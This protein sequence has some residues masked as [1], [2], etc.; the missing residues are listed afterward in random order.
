MDTTPRYTAAKAYVGAAI[1]AIVAGL[2]TLYT[3]LDDSVVSGQEAVGIASAVLI[4]LG[5]VFGGVYATT[6]APK[7]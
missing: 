5:T 6:N 4:S 7:A 3:A 1:A 2:A